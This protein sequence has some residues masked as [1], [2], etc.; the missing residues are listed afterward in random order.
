ML[1]KVGHVAILSIV[2]GRC[3]FSEYPFKRISTYTGIHPHISGFAI[4]ESWWTTTVVVLMAAMA[5]P[6]ID[7]FKT[8][9]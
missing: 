4:Q 6:V 3:L 7:V 1:G 8:F 5:L 9:K 2:L